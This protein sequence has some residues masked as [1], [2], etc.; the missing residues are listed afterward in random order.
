MGPRTVPEQVEQIVQVRPAFLR[1]LADRTLKHGALI[2]DDGEVCP[3]AELR[4]GE[5]YLRTK[6][7]HAGGLAVPNAGSLALLGLIHLRRPDHILTRIDQKSQSSSS[8][9]TALP[10]TYDEPEPEKKS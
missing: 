9:L 3:W 8:V 2:D 10:I 4:H 7:Q 1:V 5:P 6:P